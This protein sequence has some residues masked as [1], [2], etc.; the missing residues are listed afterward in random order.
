MAIIN[1]NL[2]GLH[3]LTDYFDQVELLPANTRQYLLE[4]A[5]E[6]FIFNEQ[7]SI[8]ESIHV[9]IKV[10]SVDNLPHHDIVKR[11]GQPQN[12]KEGYIKYAFPG[13]VNF[14]FS[15]IP[16][17][18]EEK[19]GVASF[20]FPHLDHIGIDIR[21]ERE[22]A[23]EIFRQVPPIAA[24][25]QWPSKKQ[26]G[27]GKKV[28]CC[29][30]QVNEKYWVYPPGNVY[31]EFAFGKLLVSENGF[32][33]DLRPSDPATELSEQHAKGCCE[34]TVTHEHPL[35]AA[36]KTVVSMRYIMRNSKGEILEDLLESEPVA[37][38]HGSGHI[39][40][41]LEE[42]LAGLKA[43]EE[44]T[45]DLGKEQGYEGVDDSFSF[46]VIIDDIRPATAEELNAGRV[47]QKHK[48][49]CGPDGCC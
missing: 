37:Y 3:D 14:I 45:F 27:D 19:A 40:P 32:G 49:E 24:S 38:L 18:Q 8:A 6:R 41:A 25:K 16:V 29:H 7:L 13:G 42:N 46:E 34:T 48:E 26:G 44:R 10:A 17:S 20:V 4:M 21:D 33:C 47:L 43:G 35:Q 2:T 23:S 15:S 9:H 36:E 30:L 39:L 1:L 12:A 5:D 28:Y 11:G 22:E 31:W